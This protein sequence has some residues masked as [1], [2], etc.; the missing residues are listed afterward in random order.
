MEDF[1]SN[2]MIN[3]CFFFFTFK[4]KLSIL[5]DVSF[6]K[7]PIRHLHVK[8]PY[9][10]FLLALMRNKLAPEAK[11]LHCT[12]CIPQSSKQENLFSIGMI[13]KFRHS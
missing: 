12:Y 9:K 5:D 8:G 2:I 3:S 4:K 6:E 13:A 7:F 1:F 10:P 11:K